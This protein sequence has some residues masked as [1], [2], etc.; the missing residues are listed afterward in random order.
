[1]AAASETAADI[2][3]GVNRCVAPV[4]GEWAFTLR[5]SI[6]SAQSK[7]MLSRP[8]YQACLR[9]TIQRSGAFNGQWSGTILHAYAIDDAGFNV[10]GR[11]TETSI[12]FRRESGTTVPA[13]FC[14]WVEVERLSKAQ[15]TTD[16]GQLAVRI[17][18]AGAEIRRLVFSDR[19]PLHG[20]MLFVGYEGI[21]ISVVCKS[22][23]WV[24]GQ[25][26]DGRRSAIDGRARRRVWSNDA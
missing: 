17:H 22:A 19:R 24:A 4:F 3:R 18:V 8:R 21:R 23:G 25:W 7:Q 5:R 12:A 1:M 20:P 6:S 11:S 14:L 16:A 10:V 13:D 2:S 15:W 9:Q 26:A